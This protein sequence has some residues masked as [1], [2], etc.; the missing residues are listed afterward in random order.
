MRIALL[1]DYPPQAAPITHRLE[2]STL[3]HA[4]DGSAGDT[5][6][7]LGRLLARLPLRETAWH[8][9]QELV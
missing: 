2:E 9:N 1:E 6:I 5:L 4:P 8:T 7:N 3:V